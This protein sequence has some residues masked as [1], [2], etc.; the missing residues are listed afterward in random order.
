MKKE[1][2]MRKGIIVLATLTLFMAGVKDLHAYTYTYHNKTCYLIKVIVEV[3]NGEDR[4][5]Q[6][7][8]N[9]SLS[10][11]TDLLL[12]SWK[13]EAFL[14][15]RWQQVLHLTCDF[16][17]GSHAFSVYVNETTDPGGTVSRNWY[18]TDQ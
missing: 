12:K 10:F 4:A 7:E 13:A 6:V 16:L 15:N 1:G 3:Y 18:S 8:P 5:N 11:S 2:T 14:D 9:G 17:P